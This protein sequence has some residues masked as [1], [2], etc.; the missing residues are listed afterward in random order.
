MNQPTRNVF[1]LKRFYND[2]ITSDLK[3][4]II[5]RTA[6]STIVNHYHHHHQQHHQH[7]QYHHQVVDEISNEPKIIKTFHVH[8][9]FLAARSDVFYKMFYGSMKESIL[10][11]NGEKSE[12]YFDHPLFVMELFLDYIYTNVCQIDGKTAIPLMQIADEFSVDDLKKLCARYVRE[13]VNFD[14]C[15]DLLELS[16][17]YNESDLS[18]QCALFIVEH[19]QEIFRT[20]G[21][22]NLSQ[23]AIITLLQR[24]DLSVPEIEIFQAVHRWYRNKLD[25]QKQTSNIGGTSNLAVT[26]GSREIACDSQAVDIDFVLSFVRLP[27]I[28]AHDLMSIVKPSDLISQEQYT[29]LLE[30]KAY[31]SA[32]L[33]E[34][35]NDICYRSRESKAQFKWRNHHGNTDFI[36]SNNGATVEKSHDSGWNLIM[37][38]D[39]CFTSGLSAWSISIDKINSDRSGMV[40]G[41][42]SDMNHTSDGYKACCGLGMSGYAYN[43]SKQVSAYGAKPG[44]FVNIIV[45]FDRDVIT[46]KLNDT[47]VGTSVKAPSMMKTVYACVFIYFESNKVTANFGM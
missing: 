34:Q 33:Q 45:D 27:L 11:N 13:E 14:N 32:F 22:L 41:V 10:N 39:K 47:V 2:E 42:V 20:D 15:C 4:H 30:Y 5:E 24:Q 18:E 23:D 44:D 19:A 25:Q 21:F 38:S 28:K 7:H 46:F 40:I 31:P 9:L 35:Q 29:K 3:L 6:S 16:S 1:N 17:L 37:V 8:K 12:I 26:I 43:I 36:L